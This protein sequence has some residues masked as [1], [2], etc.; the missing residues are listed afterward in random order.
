MGIKRWDE[1]IRR[2][3]ARPC[4]AA[5]V[6]V[7]KGKTSEQVLSQHRDVVLYMIDRWEPPPPEDS[8]FNSGSTTARLAN[9]DYRTAFQLCVNIANRYGDR[10]RMVRSDSAA[11]AR[12]YGDR[13]FD[14]V[15]IDGDHSY[16]G[17]KRDTIAWLP[18]VA[19]GG[20]IGGHDYA[21]PDQ[22]DVK[23]AVDEL[24]GTMPRLAGRELVLGENRTW[25]VRL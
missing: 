19:D 12:E 7:W 23:R 11:A 6:G 3:P 24:M 20:W 9:A 13:F 8:Y 2:L 17:V 25:W 5:E 21:H 22:G 14:L 4:F 10:A 15:F 18:K 1:I 16:D